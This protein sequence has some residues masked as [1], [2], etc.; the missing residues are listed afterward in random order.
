MK[1][2]LTDNIITAMETEQLQ[3]KK[4]EELSSILLEEKA[5]ETIYSLFMDNQLVQDL[6][7]QINMPSTELIFSHPF[8]LQDLDILQFLEVQVQVLV[9]DLV[10]ESVEVSVEVLVEASV[11]ITLMEPSHVHT[12]VQSQDKEELNKFH[13]DL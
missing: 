7:Q 5:S 8:G 11:V 12:L 3:L 13:Q 4:L 6:L 2:K 9:E 1:N 10:E